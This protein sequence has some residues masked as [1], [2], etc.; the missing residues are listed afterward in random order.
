MPGAVERAAR[1]V[2]IDALERGGKTVRV[3]LAANFAIRD[4]VEPGLLL[5]ADRE[6]GGIVLRLRQ[7][8]LLHAPELARAHPRREA[9]GE[10]LAVDQPFGLRIAADQRGRK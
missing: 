6:H 2:D 9:A 3:A 8:R 4:D 5:S 7:I 10:L 1:I